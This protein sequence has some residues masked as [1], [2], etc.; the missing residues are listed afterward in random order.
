MIVVRLLIY[1]HVQIRSQ[2]DHHPGRTAL[3]QL[4]ITG[5]SLLSTI[6]LVPV[7]S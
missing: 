6:V 7:C 5:S 1:S 3:V 4:E 2:G